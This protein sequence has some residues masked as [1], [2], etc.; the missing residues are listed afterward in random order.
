[1]VSA[2]RGSGTGVGSIMGLWSW[3]KGSPPKA[4]PAESAPEAEAPNLVLLLEEPIGANLKFV[5]DAAEHVL[6]VRLPH[7]V[8][9][10]TEFVTGDYP[11]FFL[12]TEGRLLQL[13]FM[14]RPY[15]DPKMRV[16]VSDDPDLLASRIQGDDLREAVAR[17]RG[18]VSVWCMSNQA[19]DDADSYAFVGRMLSAFAMGDVTAIVWPA[20]SEIRVWHDGMEETLKSGRPLEVFGAGKAD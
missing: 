1:M 3:L 17:H 14:H 2:F 19:G 4:A 18:W 20:R 10:S 9:D 11:F 5:Q 8:P 12:Q 6:G 7:G 16:F 15:F 13:K